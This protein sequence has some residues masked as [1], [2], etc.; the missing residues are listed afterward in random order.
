MASK[1]YRPWSPTQ[2]FLLPPS[3][4]EWLPAG[5]LAYFILDVVATLD[6]REIEAA[7]EA[8]DPRG[9]R[10]YQPAMMLA[11]LVYAYCVGVFSSRKIARATYEDVAFRVLAGGTHPH[12]T[13]INQFRLDHRTAFAGLFVQVLRLC[14]KAGLVKLGHVAFDGS[15]VAAN[16]SKHKAMSYPRM[17]EQEARLVQEVQEL[18]A[19]ADAAD[20][21]DDE[22]HGVGCA[23]EDV[24]AELQRREARLAR[25][26]EAKA[27]LEAEAA[28]ARADELR[29]RANE[30]RAK[31]AD[32]SVDAAE[33]ERAAA[34]AAESEKAADAL[35]RDDDPPKGGAS[36][37]D[38]TDLPSH[39]V[40][41]KADGNPAPTAQRNFTDADSRIMKKDGAFVQGY[42][43]QTAVDAESQVIVGEAVTNQAPDCE[44]LPPMIDR[45]ETNCG[46]KPAVLSADAGYFSRD[47]VTACEQRGV[48]AHIAVGREHAGATPANPDPVREQMRTKLRSALGKAIYA[49]RKAIVEPPFGQIKQARGFRRFSLRGLAKVRSEWTFVCLTHNLLKLFRAPRCVPSALAVA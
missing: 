32:A 33:R 20:Q 6:L 34:G 19:R 48:D 35:S 47:N 36:D 46:H 17:S 28:K 49:R 7:V 12:F 41:H 21:R 39:R 16:A 37:G 42:N 18:L 45:V 5:H 31:A 26:R 15:K 11:L 1:Q 10:P 9:E 23:P 4:L 22:K 3:P 24:P 14:Q 25:I 13:T 30:Q 8:K 38:G 43:A 27:A 44:H 29:E 40:P 2:S